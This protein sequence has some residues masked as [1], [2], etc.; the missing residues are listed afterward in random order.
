MAKNTEIELKLLLSKED[1]E[2]LLT[3]DFM[4]QAV[5]EGSRKVRHLVSTYYDTQELTLKEHGI[6]YRVRDKGDGSFEA[7]VKTQKQSAGGLS[8]RLELNLPLAEA[9]PVL[10]GFAALGLGFELSELAPCG[11]Q[12]LFTVDVQRITYILDYAGAVCELAIDKGAIRCGEK[13][14]S[15]DEVEIELL[16]GEVQAL[17]EL[18]ERIAAAV[19]L[20]A[21]ER[22][23]FA[24]G[25]ALLQ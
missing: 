22:S 8:E 14:D 18:K 13:S 4:V 10:D 2:R 6:A 11:V 16:E 19:T 5:R 20:R 25:L 23:K 9:Q 21:E 17:L 24:R 7:T 3:L 1:L 15:I 12:A